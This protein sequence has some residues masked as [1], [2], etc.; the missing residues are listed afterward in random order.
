MT[1][2]QGAFNEVET[3]ETIEKYNAALSSILKIRQGDI[4]YSVDNTSCRF[5]SNLTNLPESLRPYVRIEGKQLANIDIK[6]SQPYLS[7]ILLTDPDK[8]SPFAKS[9]ELS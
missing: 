4:F 7:I 3:F 9:K 6:N 1:I 5:H 2:D 8:V